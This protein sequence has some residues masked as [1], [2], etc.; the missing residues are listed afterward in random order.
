MSFSLEITE[1][2]QRF[3]KQHPAMLYGLALLLGFSSALNWN[4]GLLAPMIAMGLPLFF[5]ASYRR[6]GLCIRLALALLLL[7]GAFGFAKAYYQFPN[8]PLEG[9]PGTAHIKIASVS[10]KSSSFGKRW[11]YRG[12]LS[13]FEPE[14]IS[15]NEIKPSQI[16]IS[17]SL[18]Q[19][20]EITRPPAN[21]AYRV[22]GRLKETAPGNYTFLVSKDTPWYPVEGSFSLAEWRFHAKQKV[23]SYIYS[24][25]PGYRAATFLA[26]IATGD[27]DDRLMAFEFSRFGLQHIMAISGFHFAIIAAILSILLRL[28]L[29]KRKGTLFL[30]FLLSSYFVFLGCGPSIMRA[31]ITILIALMSFIVEK[32]G[33]GVNSLGVALLAVLLMDPLLCRHMGFQFSFVTTA[34]ILLFFP[35]FDLAM[36]WIFPKRPLSQMIEM[37]GLNQHGYCILTF[38]RQALALTAAVNIIALPMMLFYFQKF[39]LLSL[40]YNLFFP[41]LVSIAMLLL[42]LGLL[43]SLGIPLLGSAIHTLNGYYTQF[44]LNFTYNMPTSLDFTWRVPV[45]SLELLLFYLTFIFVTGIYL[46][47]VLDHRQEQLQDLSFI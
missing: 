24:H 46:R 25:I 1:A 39:P 42:L 28:V 23:S 4:W 5:P 36:Q 10:S 13:A 11:S 29:S 18:P 37:D 35:G 8:L 20:I 38:F 33:L 19:S 44:V 7:L 9:V 16:P 12:T 2:F 41:F 26:G 34:A 15:D 47:Y 45:F 31:W 43:F 40:V 14:N 21:G 27:F 22:Y 6:E 32:R 17:V 30:I 3:W